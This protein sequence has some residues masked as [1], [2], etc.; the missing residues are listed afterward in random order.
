M[1]RLK[2]FAL[3]R[4]EAEAIWKKTDNDPSEVFRVNTL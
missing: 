1:I 2:N 4:F 3:T